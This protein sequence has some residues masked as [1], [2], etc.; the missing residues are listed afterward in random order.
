MKNHLSQREI[1]RL[2]ECEDKNKKEY[3]NN[4]EKITFLLIGETS[5]PDLLYQAKN[6][7]KLCLYSESQDYSQLIINFEAW[8]EQY[9]TQEQLLPYLVASLVSVLA[10]GDFTILMP[11]FLG[12]KHYCSSLSQYWVSGIISATKKN[13]DLKNN[14]VNHAKQQVINIDNKIAERHPEKAQLSWI[15]PQHYDRN[16]NLTDPFFDWPWF[17]LLWQLEPSVFIKFIGECKSPYTVSGILTFAGLTDDFNLWQQAM[18]EA[19]SAF[20]ENGNW[21]GSFLL[22]MLLAEAV[23]RLLQSVNDYKGYLQKTIYLSTDPEINALIH[24]VVLTI[25]VRKDFVGIIKPWAIQL[26]KNMDHNLRQDSVSGQLHQAVLTDLMEQLHNKKQLSK[27]TNSENTDNWLY[28]S[29]LGWMANNFPQASISLPS[30]EFFVEQWLF[31]H[32]PKNSWFGAK[33]EILL[34]ISC[35]FIYQESSNSLFNNL[36]VFLTL[37]QPENTAKQWQKMWQGL[38]QLREALKFYTP[39]SKGYSQHSNDAARLNYLLLSIGLA[40]FKQLEN[41]A[42]RESPHLVTIIN[43]LFTSLWQASFTLL[44]IDSFNKEKI[45]IIQL[46]LLIMRG[47]WQKEA[48]QDHQKY[49]L[50]NKALTLTHVDLLQDLQSNITLLIALL[51]N[52]KANS[53]PDEWLKSELTDAGLNIK[54]LLSTAEQVIALNSNKQLITAQSRDTLR[55]LLV[56]D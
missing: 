52:Y 53:I 29:L 20:T 17:D 12:L 22:P 41:M 40:M 10:E 46:N 2:V 38:H 1:W 18:C 42:L 27:I 31:N 8:L 4:I 11:R 6:Q 51:P 55:Q 3:Q 21:N 19:P 25:T 56:L 47:L 43:D 14:L 16:N 7:A 39:E 44:K 49:T 9:C 15:W 45:H 34:N 32:H 33:G 28:L 36:A 13:L 54:E 50:F 24:D 37:S 48:E 26:F 5:N 35:E 30:P 23:Q